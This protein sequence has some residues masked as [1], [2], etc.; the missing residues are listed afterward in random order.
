MIEEGTFP[1]TW[2]PQLVGEEL[3][4]AIIKLG[5]EGQWVYAVIRTDN[6]KMYRTPCYKILERKIKNC[7]EGD[8]IRIIYNGSRRAFDGVEDFAVLKEERRN[9][10]GVEK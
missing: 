10:S 7:K 6:G 4:G 3:G 1:R 5:A 9:K 8:R 2:L